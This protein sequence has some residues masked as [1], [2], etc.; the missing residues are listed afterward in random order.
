M[1]MRGDN[2]HLSGSIGFIENAVIFTRSR[3]ERIKICVKI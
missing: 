3:D 2:V 1:L